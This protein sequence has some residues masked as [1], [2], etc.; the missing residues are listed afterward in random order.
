[1]PPFAIPLLL[2]LLLLYQSLLYQ[3]ASRGAHSVHVPPLTPHQTEQHTVAQSAR[4]LYPLLSPL[5]TLYPQEL[6]Y[7]ETV[8][9][10]WHER[11][12]KDIPQ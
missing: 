12:R 3:L 8:C 9:R 4:N 1:M 10:L 11:K 5:Y 2:F 7:Y 6:A